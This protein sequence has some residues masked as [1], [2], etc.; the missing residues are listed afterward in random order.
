M[1]IAMPLRRLCDNGAS[2]PVRALQN[3]GVRLRFAQT[4]AGG[5][6]GIQK[7]KKIRMEG[8]GQFIPLILIFAIMWFL[9]IR[10]QQKKL[11]EHQAMV[12]ALRKGDQVVTQG[13]MIG[14]VTR[15]KEGE[16]IEVEIAEGVRVRVVRNTIAQ[17]LSKTEPAG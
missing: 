8:F 11:K 15:V 6:R 10:P 14:K 17:V 7:R 13:G 16:E 1:A 5:V 12:A 3:P 9:L 2:G 4:R